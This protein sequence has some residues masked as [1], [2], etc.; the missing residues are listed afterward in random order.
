MTVTVQAPGREVARFVKALTRARGDVLAAQ[1]FCEGQGWTTT[2]AVCRTLVDPLSQAL[3]DQGLAPVANDLAAVLRPLTIIGRLTG[4]RR[5][6]FNCRLLTQDVGGSGD[7]VAEG[8][9]V[10]V[11]AAGIDAAIRLDARKVAAIR[12][13]TSELA[14]TMTTGSDQLIATDIAGSLVQ[15]MDLAFADPAN[16]G[17]SGKPAS[18]LNTATSFSSSGSTTA[19]IGAD[20]KRMLDT[21]TAADCSLTTASWIMH[22]ATASYLALLRDSGGPAFPGVTARGGFLLGLPVLTST[23]ITA[24]GSPGERYI[25]LIEASEVAIA[26]DGLATVELASHAAL[27]MSDAPSGGATSLVSLWQLGLVGIKGTRYMNWSRRRDG[28]AAV[29]RD[30]T[31]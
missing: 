20:L 6:P 31:Y 8:Q 14:H 7:W 19:A 25:G 27:Q 10:P 28:A 30:V 9:P 13:I 15:A 23:S 3:V 12:V 24:S 22:P 21:L 18:I 29:L 16:G 1:A 11:S 26:D 2:A 17:T 5:V 4:T